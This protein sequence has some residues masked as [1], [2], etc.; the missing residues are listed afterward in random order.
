MIGD[1]GQQALRPLVVETD[2]SPVRGVDKIGKGLEHGLLG[3]VKVQVV[4]RHIGHQGNLRVVNQKRRVG[5]VRF[6]HAPLRGACPGRNPPGR[7]HPAVHGLNIFTERFHGGGQ[8][9]R[10]RR[11]PV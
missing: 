6:N 8:N 3:P 4:C 5:F 2:D 11:F 9:R 10:R 1:L 7:D